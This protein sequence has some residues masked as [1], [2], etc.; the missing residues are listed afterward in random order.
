MERKSQILREQHEQIKE[1]FLETKWRTDGSVESAKE[2]KAHAENLIKSILD[3]LQQF[4][5]IRVDG[6][7]IKPGYKETESVYLHA[8]L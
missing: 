2:N 8:S 3:N 4:S 1:I 5:D 6:V 7:E